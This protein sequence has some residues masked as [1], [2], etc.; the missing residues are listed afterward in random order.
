MPFLPATV[1]LGGFPW[2]SLILDPVGSA[3][4]RVTMALRPRAG[5]KS[6]LGPIT[7]P[8]GLTGQIKK[9]VAG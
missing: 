2:I 7:N 1:G 5:E 4:H 6:A 3:T 9:E 8:V